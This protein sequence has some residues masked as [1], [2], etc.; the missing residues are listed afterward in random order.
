MFGQKNTNPAVS[1]TEEQKRQAIHDIFKRENKYELIEDYVLHDGNRHPFALICP[2]G[3]YSS[4]C[5]FTEGIPYAEKLNQ[6]GI[7]AFILYYRVKK[8]GRYP[9]PQQDVARALNYIFSRAEEWNLETDSYSLWGSS[10]GGHLAASFCAEGTGYPLYNLPRPAALILCYP[11]I[12]MGKLTHKGSRKNLLGK[13]ADDQLVKL[14]SVEGQV[15]DCFPPTFL[16]CGDM[17]RIVNPENSKSMAAALEKAKVPYEFHIYPGVNH[18][19]SLAQGTS[20]EEWF[21][22]AVA[23]WKKYM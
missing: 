5:S 20:A 17:D 15:T 23:F 18:G 14:L 13:K 3:G 10:A 12:T 4:V 11:V 8:A 1:F 9:V 2:G 7:S 21:N 19:A 6:N 16:W 22:L